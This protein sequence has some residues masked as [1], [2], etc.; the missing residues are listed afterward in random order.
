VR[1]KKGSPDGK[2]RNRL[3]W[4]K[5]SPKSRLPFETEGGSSKKTRIKEVC[6]KG[7]KTTLTLCAAKESK[8]M[9]LAFLPACR[10]R[11]SEAEGKGKIAESSY[12]LL[13]RRGRG[14][15]N[16]ASAAILS[17]KKMDTP[18]H[19]TQPRKRKKRA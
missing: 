4:K 13:G 6:F 5:R 10:K 19:L 9:N 16:E 14:G 17:K 1:T 18:E 12:A 2:R 7:T 15:G 8:S 3:V 11:T